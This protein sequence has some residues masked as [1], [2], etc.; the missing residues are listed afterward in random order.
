MV[1]MYI[2]TA[3][4]VDER[5]RITRHKQESHE[6]TVRSEHYGSLSSGHDESCEIAIFEMMLPRQKENGTSP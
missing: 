2:A 5:R 6:C 1:R 3:G 4:W